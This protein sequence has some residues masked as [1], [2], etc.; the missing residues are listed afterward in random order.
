M[1]G[2]SPLPI[3]SQPAHHSHQGEPKVTGTNTAIAV[4]DEVTNWVE[5][6]VVMAE[7]RR[8]RSVIKAQLKEKGGE[9]WSVFL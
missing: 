4:E 1:E 5:G 7:G 3:P 8:K 9:E 2:S 6:E